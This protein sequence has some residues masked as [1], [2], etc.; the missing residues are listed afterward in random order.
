MYHKGA[1]TK[2]HKCLAGHKPDMSWFLFLLNISLMTLHPMECPINV[3]LNKIK[4]LVNPSILYFCFDI[5]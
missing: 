4:A 2:M 5:K 1:G 3:T